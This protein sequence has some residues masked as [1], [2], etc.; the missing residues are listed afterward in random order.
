MAE[1]AAA[2]LKMAEEAA[3]KAN[4]ENPILPNTL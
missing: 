1:E 3:E 4:Q 2:K